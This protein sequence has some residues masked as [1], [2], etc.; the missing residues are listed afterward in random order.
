MRTKLLSQPGK[1]GI[2]KSPGLALISLL[3]LQACVSTDLKLSGN[4][5]HDRADMV[6][7]GWS[8]LN[9]VSMRAAYH[10]RDEEPSAISEAPAIHIALV[11]NGGPYPSRS[12]AARAQFSTHDSIYFGLPADRE[13]LGWI[14]SRLENGERQ[15]YYSAMVEIPDLGFDAVVLPLGLEGMRME[16]FTHTHPERR[17]I[18][19]DMFSLTDVRFVLES[20]YPMYLRTPAGDVRVLEPESVSGSRPQVGVSVCPGLRAFMLPLST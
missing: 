7:N 15:Y 17:K 13:L 12:K 1:R 3:L 5:S 9:W 8:E 18:A 16:A 2:P 11:R 14:G 19:Q 6:M 4:P 20:G 10:A